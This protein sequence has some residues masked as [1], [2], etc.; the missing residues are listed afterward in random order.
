VHVHVCYMLYVVC[1]C[2]CVA[3]CVDLCLLGLI[4]LKPDEDE[5]SA[6]LHS[7]HLDAEDD[8]YKTPPAVRARRS[9]YAS[10]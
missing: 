7:A 2:S 4:N 3:V 9:A 5:E 10:I 8:S 6:N 1:V